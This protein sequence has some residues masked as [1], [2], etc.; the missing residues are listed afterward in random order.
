MILS[1]SH[2]KVQT[3]KCE[4]IFLSLILG[5]P[6]TFAWYSMFNGILTQ[7]SMLPLKDGHIIVYSDGV[8]HKFWQ[9]QEDMVHTIL[10]QKS[11]E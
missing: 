11:Q 4:E 3:I 7:R 10:L 2:S 6:Y 1:P 5:K 9:S 8:S